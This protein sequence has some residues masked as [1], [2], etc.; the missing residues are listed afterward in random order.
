MNREM[1][2]EILLEFSAL[3]VFYFAL[4]D[5]FCSVLTRRLAFAIVKRYWKVSTGLA[6]GG[7]VS[8][9]EED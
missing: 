5:L 4:P 9:E 2:G 1:S 6:G 3:E 7:P 8:K